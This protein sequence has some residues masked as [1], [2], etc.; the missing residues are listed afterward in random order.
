MDIRATQPDHLPALA[1]FLAAQGLD[2]GVDILKWKFPADT[3]SPPCSWVALLGGEI[4]GHIGV[5]PTTIAHPLPR[6]ESIPAGWFVDWMVREDLRS[7]GIGIFLL[8]EALA[9]DRILMTI[10]GSADTRRALP[11]LGWANPAM[12]SLYKLNLRPT[13][14]AAGLLQSCA[15]YAAQRLWFHPIRYR[16]P[17]NWQLSACDVLD[18]SGR[19]QLAAALQHI[20]DDSTTPYNC[21][22]RSAAFL[23]WWL[24]EHPTRRYHFLIASDAGSPGGYAVWRTAQYPDGRIEARIV[25]LA[26][27]WNRPDVW[28]WLASETTNRAAQSEASQISCLAGPATPLAAALRQ[29]R[30]LVRQALPL[31]ISPTEK[32]VPTNPWHATLADSDIDTSAEA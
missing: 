11:Q 9:T 26:A 1:T 6:N 28:T 27:P 16:P 14:A 12:L 2:T 30:F 32:P 5:I 31:W 19:A 23:R 13:A 8:R 4:V 3:T 7:R 18:G 20:N 21:F 29:N 25:D 24:G 15:A 22:P 10:Q 17:Q